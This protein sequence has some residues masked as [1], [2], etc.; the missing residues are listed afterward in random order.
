VLGVITSLVV[1]PSDFTYFQNR[2]KAQLLAQEA[3]SV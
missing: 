3:V 1:E 2:K